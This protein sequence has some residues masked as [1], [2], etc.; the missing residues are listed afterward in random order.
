V[1]IGLL[2]SIPIVVFGST[3]V[4]KLVE[5]FPS[6]MYLGAGVL[7]FTAGKMIVNE[8]LLAKHLQ[9][10]RHG[11]PACV[12]GRLCVCHRGV[13]AAGWLRQPSQRPERAPRPGGL[14]ALHAISPTVSN[15]KKEP[16]WKNHCVC[17][18]RRPRATTTHPHER[19]A[20]A[21]GAGRATHW[22]V[23]ACAPRM[24]HRISKWVSHSA[25][26]NWRAKWADKL[27]DQIVPGSA[28]PGDLV[29]TVLAKGPL[30][31][32]TQKLKAEHGTSRVLDARRPK[33][34]QPSPPV[35]AD[36]P[37]PTKTG[38]GTCREPCWAWAPCWCWR[39]ISARHQVPG[40][41]RPRCYALL[42]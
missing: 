11:T 40:P 17:G 23:V 27:F 31:E 15:P 41:R 10:P 32:L 18:R 20:T 3:L 1:V 7:A 8:K 30:T 19:A 5:R 2:V 28:G 35:T 12:L 29:T 14:S 22:V 42:P 13:L 36:Q 24:T 26:E 16:S 4:L 6:I 39:R 21:Q 9:G 38:A 25:R 37:A 33:L 34:G